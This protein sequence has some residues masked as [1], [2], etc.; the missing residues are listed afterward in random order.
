[1]AKKNASGRRWSSGPKVKKKDRKLWNRL[2]KNFYAELYT[3]GEYP[4][5]AL[6]TAPKIDV[7]AYNLAYIALWEMRH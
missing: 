1:M 3:S 7:L 5:G 6:L 4:Y 2:Y